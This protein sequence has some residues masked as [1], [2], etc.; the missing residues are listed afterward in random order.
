MASPLQ[1]LPLAGPQATEVLIFGSS[2]LIDH[3]FEEVSV[4]GQQKKD[5]K[6]WSFGNDREVFFSWYT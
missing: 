1:R 3:S 6:I 4:K 2:S 5:P